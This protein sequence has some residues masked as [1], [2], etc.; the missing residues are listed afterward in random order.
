MVQLKL[1][2]RCC[3]AHRRRRVQ[4]WPFSRCSA[5]TTGPDRAGRQTSACNLWRL[6]TRSR[7]R[8]R[9]MTVSRPQR[10]PA[11]NCC[12]EYPRRVSSGAEPSGQFSCCSAAVAGPGARHPPPRSSSRRLHRHRRGGPGGEGLSVRVP[13]TRRRE[14]AIRVG[15]PEAC[16]DALV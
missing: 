6:S 10:R 3:T 14:A 16:S 9:S 12:L 8:R 4:G 5:A 11:R 7:A 1:P 13:P 2:L 15:C